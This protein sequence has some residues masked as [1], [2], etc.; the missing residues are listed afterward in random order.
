MTFGSVFFNMLVQNK[1]TDRNHFVS[2]R[3]EFDSVGKNLIRFYD[4]RSNNR[5]KKELSISRLFG[6]FKCHLCHP[7]NLKKQKS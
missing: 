5:A 1:K 2:T 7:V 3:Q 4:M 6:S